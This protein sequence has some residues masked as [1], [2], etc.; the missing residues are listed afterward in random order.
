MKTDV[1]VIDSPLLGFVMLIGMDIIRM[2][3][4]VRIN[5]SGDAIFSRTEL[6]A[7]AVIRIEELDFSTEF[8]E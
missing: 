7:C 6:C 2:L 8:D 3:G 4:G 1:L 5:Q